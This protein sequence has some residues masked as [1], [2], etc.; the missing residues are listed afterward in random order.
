MKPSAYEWQFWPSYRNKVPDLL[1]ETQRFERM[2]IEIM[3]IDIKV[4]NMEDLTRK[5]FAA[6]HG[7]PLATQVQG[8][9]A[10]MVESTSGSIPINA[11]L[12]GN[13]AIPPRVACLPELHRNSRLRYGRFGLCI[14]M[15]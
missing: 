15:Y 4:L 14:E 11:H 6:R 10:G 1:R 5:A 9:T 2:K 3:K 13:F 8:S 12:P 7:T